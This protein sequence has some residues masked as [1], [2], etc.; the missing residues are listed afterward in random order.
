[1]LIGYRIS[2]NSFRL[3]PSCEWRNHFKNRFKIE[4]SAEAGMIFQPAI[5]TLQLEQSSD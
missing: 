2:Q 5:G 4:M 3:I 1:M